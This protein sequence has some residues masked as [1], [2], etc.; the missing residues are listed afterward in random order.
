MLL[1]LMAEKQKGKG[2][3]AKERKG[4]R[5]PMISNSFL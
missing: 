1:Q 4:G 5:T 2:A 3:H